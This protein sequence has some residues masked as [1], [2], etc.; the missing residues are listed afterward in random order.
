MSDG[1]GGAG[2]LGGVLVAGALYWIGIA[3]ALP[4]GLG[5]IANALLVVWTVGIVGASALFASILMLAYVRSAVSDRNWLWLVDL[6]AAPTVAMV[7]GWTL[8]E[9][10]RGYWVD[11]TRSAND[12]AGSQLLGGGFMF[13]FF[14]ASIPLSIWGLGRWPEKGLEGTFRRVLIGYLP[15][16]FAVGSWVALVAN[17]VDPVPVKA[18]AAAALQT[19][20]K[21]R[22]T[23]AADKLVVEAGKAVSEKTMRLHAVTVG[24]PAD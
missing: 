7:V 16:I 4:L 18:P 2:V 13:V 3:L 1:G 20:C 11:F 10:F 9:G 8:R 21:D 12:S 23:A 5:L 24:D 19:M 6:F 17:S 15:M 14:L 22:A